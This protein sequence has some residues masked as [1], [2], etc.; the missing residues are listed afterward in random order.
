[1]HI[2]DIAPR[3][4][5]LPAAVTYHR[6]SAANP[7]TIGGVIRSESFVGVIHFAGV[8]LDAWC[9]ARPLE[10]Q[11]INEGSA[12]EVA[13][14]VAAQAQQAGGAW[15]K[16]SVPWLI[17]GSSTEVYGYSADKVINEDSATVP[18]SHLGKTMLAAEQ[19]F[20]GAFRSQMRGIILRF[21]DVYGYPPTSAIEEGQIPTLVRNSLASLTVQFDSDTEPQDM[22]YVD[23]AVEAVIKAVEHVSTLAGETEIFNIVAGPRWPIED[24]VERTRTITSSLSPFVDIGDHRSFFTASEFGAAK[25]HNTFAWQSSTELPVGLQKTISTYTKAQHAWTFSYIQDQCP[26]SSLLPPDFIPKRHAADERNKPLHKLDKCLV[27]LAFNH[28]GYLHHMKCEDGKTCHADGDY[29]SGY[30]WNSTYWIVH[31]KKGERERQARLMFEEEKGM[32]FLGLSMGLKEKDEAIWTL[33]EEDADDWFTGFDVEVSFFEDPRV[34]ARLR[35]IGGI[36]EAVWNARD[37]LSG[38]V[39]EGRMVIG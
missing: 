31:A 1:M 12:R 27:S 3:P 9:A 6:G 11:N 34:R 13:R 7:S 30:N 15:R 23:D 18:N 32:G 5:D 39:W 10:C 21:S 35:A 4:A 8:T 33:V 26:S 29:V 28:E 38:P 24:I 17:M 37:K 14:A 2:L 25:A 22:V 36:C 16:T 20:T 19:A